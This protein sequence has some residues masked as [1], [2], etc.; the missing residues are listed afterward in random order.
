MVAINELLTRVGAL[1]T[2]SSED[3]GAVY[4]SN[5]YPVSIDGR[6]A[7]CFLFPTGDIPE[8]QIERG[9]GRSEDIL[10]RRL[11]FTASFVSD[12]LGRSISNAMYAYDELVNDDDF[13]DMIC[14]QLDDLNITFG[15]SQA[16]TRMNHV[17][18]S[19]SVVYRAKRSTF[20]LVK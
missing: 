16:E 1:F 13:N 11:S 10:T 14:G 3:I 8:S 18:F 6:A 7:V 2:A 12:D 9:I 19:L 4:I 20:E 17:S 5:P 15:A